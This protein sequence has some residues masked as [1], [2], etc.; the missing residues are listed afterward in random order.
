[1]SKLFSKVWKSAKRN[2]LPALLDK[3]DY[4]EI[5]KL[6]PH[7]KTLLNAPQDKKPRAMWRLTQFLVDTENTMPRNSLQDE[8]GFFF[9]KQREEVAILKAICSAVLRKASP[10]DLHRAGLAGRL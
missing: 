7:L 9:C 3:Y 6:I 10:L 8:Y 4:S 5:W 1:T 2:K